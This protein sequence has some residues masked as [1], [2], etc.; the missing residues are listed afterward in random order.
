MSKIGK[1]TLIEPQPPGYHVYSRV[2][3][4]RLGL[5][6]LGAILKKKG[7]DVSIYCQGF[8]PI[9]YDD[10]L[11]SDLVGISTTTSTASEGY[12]IADRVR[13]AGIPVAMGGSHVS[14]LADEALE[15]ADFCV[16]GEG[17][18]SFPELIDAV[19]AGSGFGGIDGL[20]YRIGD[21]IRHNPNRGLVENLDDIP[22]ADLSLI[23]G[24]DKI[25]LTPLST[26]RG[27]P[28]DCNFCSVTKMF[29]RRYR[30]RSIESVVDEIERLDPKKL[31]FYDDNFTANPSRSKEM[32]ETMLSRGVVPKWTAQT[33]ADVVRDRELLKLMKRSNCYMVYVGFESVNPATLEEYNK[34]QTVDEIVEAVRLLHEH[35][36]MTHGMFIFGADHDDAASLRSTVE[37]ALKNH[38]DTVQL[39]VL[40]P[41]PGTPFFS[42]MEQQGRLL[43]KEWHLFDGHH[44]VHQPHQM[45]PV[46]LQM[47]W[48]RAVKRFYSLGEC[49][50]MLFG[51]DFLKFAAK[52]NANLLCGRWHSAKRQLNARTLKW[53]YRA[54]GHFLINRWDAANKD[55]GERVKALADRACALRV[56]KGSSPESIEHNA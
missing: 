31:F 5:P 42:D 25:K 51:V 46:E 7:I 23:S 35:G 20:S 16:R 45:S 9:D 28:F 47:E 50:K 44:V 33:R 39:V 4:P 41:L 36:I 26:S 27:C 6:I 22:F 56:Q 53:F 34:R 19:D 38:I 8:E 37:F 14:F 11:S 10:V 24:H 1:V 2:A 17:E 54:Y 30:Q 49:A 15:H 55:V 48:F 29:G 13:E 40:T 32:L 3:L 18:Y 12:R 43:T 21:D 52:F